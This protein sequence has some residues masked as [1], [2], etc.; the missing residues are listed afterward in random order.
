MSQS[1]RFKRF[2]AP[3]GRTTFLPS[4]T[5]ISGLQADLQ[6]EEVPAILFVIGKSGSTFKFAYVRVTFRHAH[7]IIRKPYLI[8]LKRTEYSSANFAPGQIFF[9][10]SSHRL[11]ITDCLIEVVPKIHDSSKRQIFAFVPAPSGE[12]TLSLNCAISLRIARNS[13]APERLGAA[14]DSCWVAY[15]T[16][17]SFQLI[18]FSHILPFFG[19][20]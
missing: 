2:N 9:I 4:A 18:V 7:K 14:N 11:K 1:G 6:T 10:T 19:P 12:K 3:N 17:C 5:T 15:A 16:Q 20:G 13:A 8:F